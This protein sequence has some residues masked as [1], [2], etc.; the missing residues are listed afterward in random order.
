MMPSL[1][2]II[3]AVSG[4]VSVWFSR[5]ASIWVYP[6]GLINTVFYIWISYDAQLIGE[7]TVNFYYTVMSLYG[8]FNWLRR[9]E[10]R[11]LIVQITRSTR[12]DW[13]MQCAFFIL[14]YL[15][16]FVSLI[17]LQ[18]AF[19]PGAIPWADALASAAAFTGMWLMTQKKVES[20]LWW[21]ITNIASMPLYFIK[22]YAFTAGYYFILLVLAVLGW[23]EW[24]KKSQSNVS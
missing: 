7:A 19:F 10:K 23:R 11:E 13:L 18:D 9:N 17:Y 2:E 16:L 6:T 22:G 5:K 3:A 21:I 4:I 15:V 14:I 1:F 12:T 20:W 24:V 8:W